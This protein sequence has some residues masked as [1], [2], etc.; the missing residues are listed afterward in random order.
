MFVQRQAG[1]LP[2]FGVA[3]AGAEPG[4]DAS[5]LQI[6]Q[7]LD[8][9]EGSRVGLLDVTGNANYVTLSYNHFRDHNKTTLIGSSDTATLTDANPAVLKTTLH[10]NFYQNLIQRQPRILYGMVHLYGNY[11]EGVNGGSGYA[12]SYGWYAGQGSKIYSENNVFHITGN[13]ASVAGKLITATSSAAKVSSCAA[14][15]GMSTQYC[16]AYIYDTGTFLNGVSVNASAAAN[17]INALINPTAMP[18]P[19]K[20]TPTAAPSATPSSYYSYTVTPATNLSTF[21]PT[22]A[23]AGKL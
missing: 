7:G 11:Y 5:A 15:V 13:A 3:P 12:W 2:H 4:D 18:W 20:A 14:L 8:L 6:A 17:S 19:S 23:G 22:N 16:S 9:S 10:H 21:V 1:R